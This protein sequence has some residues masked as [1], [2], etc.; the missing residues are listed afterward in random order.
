MLLFSG[1]LETGAAVLLA[2][3]AEDEDD[4]D[5]EDGEKLASSGIWAMTVAAGAMRKIFVGVL[6]HWVDP[7]PSPPGSQ[8]LILC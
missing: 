6:Q 4:E 1:N 2:V 5:D 3:A 8:Q 7:T